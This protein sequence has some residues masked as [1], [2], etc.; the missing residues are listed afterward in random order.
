MRIIFDCPKLPFCGCGMA[1]LVG[2]SLLLSHCRLYSKRKKPK[3]AILP[4]SSVFQVNDLSIMNIKVEKSKIF[5]LLCIWP[6]LRPVAF[7]QLPEY[8]FTDI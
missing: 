5:Q 2:F 3:R 4:V 1:F 7:W 6:A 8:L